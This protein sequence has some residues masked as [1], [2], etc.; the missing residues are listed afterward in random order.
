LH[1]DCNP[2]WQ[3]EVAEQ[4]E[5]VRG[6]LKT[7]PPDKHVQL[8]RQVLDGEITREEAAQEAQ[9]HP[10]T[11]GRWRD[12]LVKCIQRHLVGSQR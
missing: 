10:S 4:L 11:I 5:K 7:L 9:V 12:K 6:F 3:V 1:A 2:E 8:A